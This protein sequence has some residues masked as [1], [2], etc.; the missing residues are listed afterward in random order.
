[1]A[2]SKSRLPASIL[3]ITSNPRLRRDAATSSASFLGL[4]RARLEFLYW[5]LP[6]TSATRRS[7]Q[8]AVAES[9]AKSNASRVQRSAATQDEMGLV[10]L[11]SGCSPS[12]FFV[13]ILSQNVHARTT[14]H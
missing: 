10:I 12:Q 7:A 3:R 8:A 13:S 4:K 6:T 1:M 2:R 14:G 9:E 11:N 5:E